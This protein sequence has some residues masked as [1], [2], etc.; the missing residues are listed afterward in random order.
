VVVGKSYC[1]RSKEMLQFG[2]FVWRKICKLYASLAR[3]DRRIKLG[4]NCT[5]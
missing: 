4:K 5:E 3:I 2:K 1:K